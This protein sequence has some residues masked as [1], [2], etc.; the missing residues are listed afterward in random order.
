LSD[1]FDGTPCLVPVQIRIA[2]GKAARGFITRLAESQAALSSDPPLELGQVVVL[3]FRKPGD[4]AH[5]E[6]RAAVGEL[7]SSGGLWRGRPAARVAFDEPLRLED[8][9]PWQPVGQSR[10]ATP[11]VEEEPAGPPPVVTPPRGSLGAVSATG[12]GPR[13][14]APVHAPESALHLNE[15]GEVVPERAPDPFLDD[16]DQTAPGRLVSEGVQDAL[17]AASLP[18]SAI[19]NDDGSDDFLSQFGRVAEPSWQWEADETDV[20]DASIPAP[21]TQ[22]RTSLPSMPRATSGDTVP[23]RGAPSGRMPAAGPGRPSPLKD[24]SRDESMDAPPVHSTGKVAR[25]HAALPPAKGATRPPWEPP[26]EQPSLIPRNLRIASTLEVRFWAR[27]R[28]QAAVA[29]NFSREGLYLIYSGTPP[30]RGAIVRIEFPLRG[31]D[32]EVSVRFNAEVR[33]HRSDRPTVGSQD[34]FGVRILTFET[35]KDRGRYE[36]IVDLILSLEEPSQPAEP[37]P[38]WGVPGHR[39]R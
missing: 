12:L 4:D 38:S 2:G 23:A 14:R 16:D 19:T 3:S 20:P 11:A 28:S 27:G 26:R 17:D 34:G 36:E 1:S 21:K 24:T 32:E 18:E 13:R 39:F 33:W 37:E 9:V 15:S 22:S 31:D 5:V 7:L 6:V 29:A 25:S 35:P 30:V 10:L 8:A